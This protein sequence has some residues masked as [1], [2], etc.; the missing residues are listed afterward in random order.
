MQDRV[1]DLYPAARVCF[2]LADWEAGAHMHPNAISA[3]PVE[4]A[5]NMCSA[6]PPDVASTALCREA[7]EADPLGIDALYPNG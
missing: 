7:I 2:S 6:A 1:E 4:F 5:Y 3:D